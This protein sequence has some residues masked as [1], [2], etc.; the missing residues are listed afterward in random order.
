VTKKNR[1][2]QLLRDGKAVVGT[3]LTENATPETARM[4]GAAGFDFIF[5]DTE[6]GPFTF[7]TVANVVRAAKSVGLTCLV[8]VTDPEYHLIARTLDAGA[9]GLMIP[10]VETRE[11]VEKII[12]AAKYPPMGERGYGPRTIITDFEQMSVRD[13]TSEQNE[14]TLIVL[15]I[16]KKSAIERI[17]DLVAVK[18]VDVALIGPND[19]SISL[20]VPGEFENPAMIDAIQK[21]ATACEK[22]GIAS[23]THVRD[24][25]SL[26]FWKSR[27]MR[28]LTY[29][30]DANML[31]GAASDAVKEIRRNL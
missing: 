24:M 7:E 15:Q 19:L 29:S 12:S 25:R 20:G 31:L 6:H 16:E 13:L 23:G 14:D 3:M 18:G 2:K 26:L 30:T 9:Q 22:H 11:S 8:R 28:M 5:I 21:V 27:G 1:T 4:M 17:E 10:R